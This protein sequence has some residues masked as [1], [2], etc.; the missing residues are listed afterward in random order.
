MNAK[1]AKTSTTVKGDK[2]AATTMK[3][4]QISAAQS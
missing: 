2:K 4:T 1:K 3:K